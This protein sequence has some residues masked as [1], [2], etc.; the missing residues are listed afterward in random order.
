MFRPLSPLELRAGDGEP[1]DPVPQAPRLGQEPAELHHQP[2]AQRP[3][4]RPR[5]AQAA[6]RLPH[7]RGGPHRRRQ[8]PAGLAR[9]VRFTGITACKDVH[10]VGHGGSWT[11]GFRPVVGAGTQWATSLS[12]VII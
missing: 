8:E 1:E 6:Q 10:R 11:T 7:L 4:R 12:C 5:H 2:A 9:Q 3:L